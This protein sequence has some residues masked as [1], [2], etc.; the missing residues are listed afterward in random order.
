MMMVMMMMM[1]MM[2]IA[3]ELAPDCVRLLCSEQF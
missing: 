2:C 1:M 3:V